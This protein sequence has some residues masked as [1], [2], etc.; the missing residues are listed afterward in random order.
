MTF[1]TQTQFVV[2]QRLTAFLDL[3]PFGF[4]D[5]DS[6]VHFHRTVFPAVKRVIASHA[7]GLKRHAGLL[8]VVLTTDKK[9]D[10]GSCYVELVHEIISGKKDSDD[11]EYL[12]SFK[13][14][15]VQVA[16]GICQII[17]CPQDEINFTKNRALIVQDLKQQFH[18]Q[19]ENQ[20]AVLRE[21]SSNSFQRSVVNRACAKN[22]RSKDLDALIKSL[23]DRYRVNG[24]Y[25]SR[26]LWL[27][28]IELFD[29]RDASVFSIL[30]DKVSDEQAL[31]N[32]NAIKSAPVKFVYR[33]SYKT[34]VK[35]GEERFLTYS[36]FRRRLNKLMSG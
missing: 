29:S 14:A 36:S 11:N 2:Q 25:D 30:C 20:K 24:E 18:C 19:K 10:A 6:L 12:S 3:L 9:F 34:G 26:N 28:L 5:G 7:Q 32:N 16:A 8:D 13:R 35:K 31:L 1:I 21:V 15:E 27:Y 22:S 23:F 17:D 33:Y 4:D